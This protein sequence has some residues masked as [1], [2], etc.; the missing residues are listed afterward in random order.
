MFPITASALNDFVG[1][2][3][4]E[5]CNNHYDDV[6]QNHCAH[7]VSHALDLKM[8]MLCGDVKFETRHSGAS[9]RCNEIYNNLIATGPWN[10]RPTFADGILIF[11]ISARNIRNGKMIDVPQKHVGIFFAGSVYNY[12]NAHHKVVRDSTVDQFHNKFKHLYAGG[13]ISLYFGSLS[14]LVS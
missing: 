9:I 1:K 7:F 4:G 10:E 2:S 3:I 11:V 8:G 12:S 14:V 6:H 5:I 13:D